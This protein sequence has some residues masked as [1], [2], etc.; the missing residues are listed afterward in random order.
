ME[1]FEE[2]LEGKGLRIGICG[3]PGNRYSAA[4]IA[5]LAESGL[6]VISLEDALD[7]E[8]V[9]A[10]AQEAGIDLDDLKKS[11]VVG[12][13]YIENREELIRG[14]IDSVKEIPVPQ[15]QVE[16]GFYDNRAGRRAQ[17][18]AERRRRRR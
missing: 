10:Q 5:R 4:D 15:L 13:G 16:T 17:A 2:K 3:G 7:N 8:E 11:I 14:L 9:I 1:S 6:K 12:P 18:K